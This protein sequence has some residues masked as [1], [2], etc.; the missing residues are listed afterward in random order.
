LPSTQ[1]S[2]LLSEAGLTF[3]GVVD[4]PVKGG[5]IRAL[6]FSLTSAESTPFELRIPGLNGGPVFSIK[7]SK[8]TVS[9]HVRLYATR[10]QGLAGGVLPQDYTPDSPPP[11]TPP[12]IFFT[13]ATVQLVFIRA[14]KLTAA[15]LTMGFV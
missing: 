2:A 6:Q 14:D 3:D 11:I 8:L 13:H 1:I 5:T 9:G 4:L 10:I 15:Q 7:S 12:V